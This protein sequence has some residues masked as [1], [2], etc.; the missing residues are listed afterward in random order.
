MLMLSIVAC[1]N[2]EP[3]Q[4]NSGT[5]VYE[6]SLHEQYMDLLNDINKI[7]ITN[8]QTGELMTIDDPSIV[9]QW[10]NNVYRLPIMLNSNE[11]AGAGFLYSLTLYDDEQDILSFSNTEINEQ[12]T[13]DAH[14]LVNAIETLIN[15]VNLEKEKDHETVKGSEY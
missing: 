12:A 3:S 11:K 8:G 10:I 4:H 14:A 5:T 6:S 9:T 7:E 13:V 15:K 2:N 1:K